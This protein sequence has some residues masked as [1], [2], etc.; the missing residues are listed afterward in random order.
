MDD[1][2]FN[3]VHKQSFLRFS[4]FLIISLGIHLVL[5]SYLVYSY[6]DILSE[7]LLTS[8][9]PKILV[10]LTDPRDDLFDPN[11][12]VISRYNYAGKGKLSPKPGQHLSGGFNPI[13]LPESSSLEKPKD[14][15]LI[16]KGEKDKKIKLPINDKGELFNPKKGERKVFPQFQAIDDR[17]KSDEKRRLAI[18]TED[19]LENRFWFDESEFL[20]LSSRKHPDAEFSLELANLL[21]KRFSTYVLGGGRFNFYHVKQD[22]A[23]VLASINSTG[24]ISFEKIVKPSK[25]QPYM[26]YLVSRV[27]DNPGTVKH[28]PDELRD[29]NFDILYFL[30]DIRFTGE[31]LRKWWMGFEFLPKNINISR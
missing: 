2:Q 25:T 17:K 22:Q 9:S 21:K 1:R 30:F 8:R 13:T 16:Q 20:Q 6:R 19:S 5:F 18:D 28:L 3:P 31:P 15:P 10:D 23:T 24:K 4:V 27:V 11:K 29:K 7:I 12:K 26:N 14:K